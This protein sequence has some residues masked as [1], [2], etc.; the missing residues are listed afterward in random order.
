MEIKYNLKELRLSNNETL[1]EL[2]ERVG[3]SQPTL[4]RY[5]R[6]TRKPKYEQVVKLANHFGVSVVCLT[7]TSNH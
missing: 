7:G 3:I 2:S 4:S 5:E 6:G 1:T